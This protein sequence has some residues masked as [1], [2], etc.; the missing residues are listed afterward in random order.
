VSRAHITYGERRTYVAQ[1]GIDVTTPEAGHYRFR[2]GSGTVAGGVKI[3][4]GAP[5]DPVTGEE[6]DRSWR[7]QALF[8]GEPV[9]FDRVWP[10]CTGQPITEQEYR[11]YCVQQDWAR[12]H[13][14]GSAYAQ[15]GRRREPLSLSEP[16]PF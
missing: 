7:W 9:D 15:P 10:A 14:P 11:R 4:F 13:A 6:L 3:W 5:H 2:M 12:R 16:L 8:N 1:R